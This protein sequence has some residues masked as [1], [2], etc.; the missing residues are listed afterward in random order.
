MKLWSKDERIRVFA[1]EQKLATF[2][3]GRGVVL[4]RKMTVGT[5]R[6]KIVRFVVVRILIDVV[7]LRSI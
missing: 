3:L 4:I 1:E 6:K 2:Q 5:Q 7:D